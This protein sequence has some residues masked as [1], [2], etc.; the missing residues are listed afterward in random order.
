MNRVTFKDVIAGKR[1]S[2]AQEVDDDRD[3]DD[4]NTN[5]ALGPSSSRRNVGLIEG[6]ENDSDLK[7]NDVGEVLE[8]FNM[9]NERD[10]GHIDSNMNFVYQKDQDG[11]LDA[12]VA[13]LDEQAMEKAIGDAAR[14]AQRKKTLARKSAIDHANRAPS[15]SVLQLK[16][17]LVRT[18]EDGETIAQ[19]IK[20][21]KGQKDGGDGVK[22]DTGKQ[23]KKESNLNEQLDN[24]F[25]ILNELT[26]AG[27]SM[28]YNDLKETIERDFVKWEYQALD[29]SLQGPFTHSTI[30]AWV[31]Q[32]FF[33]TTPV[34][35]RKVYNTLEKEEP[36]SSSLSSSVEPA[37]KRTKVEDIAAD[38][39]DSDED[40]GKEMGKD[41]EQSM[42][43]PGSTMLRSEWS[44]SSSID[45]TLFDS[46]T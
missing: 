46:I 15:R 45:F 9:K 34:Y 20:R 32:G 29:G 5:G 37:R 18:M 28:D 6:E 39:D 33:S 13:N 40:N 12:W 21:L 26:N 3:S 4:E 17:A 16:I 14:A 2:L 22:R 19:A 41:G 24:F 44:L 27:D 7:F 1:D 35:M 11:E 25:D 38:F 23:Q 42:A 36:P 31:A 43:P 30:S 10:G 8:P